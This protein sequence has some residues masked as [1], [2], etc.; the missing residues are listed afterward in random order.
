MLISVVVAL[1][2]A[3]AGQPAS[4]DFTGTWS[5]VP[6]RS[7][8]PQQSE[9]I[10]RMTFVITQAGDQIR[11][12]STS[13]NDKPILATYV[14]GPV[15]KQPSEPLSADQSRAYWQG[16]KLIVERGG[17]ISGQTVSSKQTLTLS[18]D[19][20]ELTVERLVIVQHG[21]TLK[22]T[23]NYATVTDVFRRAR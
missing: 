15:P 6:D 3:V 8:S 12:E 9:P 20:S 4:T 7:G 5:M 19:R 23:P 18:P 17:T 2:L 10:T 11:I 16:Q 14:F 13:G 21:Y 22:G 1:L